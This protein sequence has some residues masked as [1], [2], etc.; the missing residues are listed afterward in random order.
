MKIRQEADTLGDLLDASVEPIQ[1]TPTTT[2][3]AVPLPPPAPAV[4]APRP[5]LP[6]PGSLDSRLSVIP[7]KNLVPPTQVVVRV[8]HKFSKDGARPTFEVIGTPMAGTTFD[9]GIPLSPFVPAET[10]RVYRITIEEYAGSNPQPKPNP[11][12]QGEYR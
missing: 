2:R 9:G 5:A 12:K 6:P 7:R 4:S 10:G 11:Y 8:N 1:D 3:P